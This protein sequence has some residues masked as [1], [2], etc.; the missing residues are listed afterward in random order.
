MTREEREAREMMT[1]RLPSPVELLE[2]LI[3][4]WAAEACDA[5]LSDD[6]L[7]QPEV[8]EDFIE[9]LSALRARYEA[10][11]WQDI[12]RA[13][14]D[15]VVLVFDDGYIGKGIKEDDGRWRDAELE[16]ESFYDPPPTHWRPLPPPPTGG[17]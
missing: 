16:R 5:S 10:Q 7:A 2:A 8:Y 3:Q 12:A 9:D 13:P 14:E 6:P 4:K 11:E 1:E 17:K 15:E